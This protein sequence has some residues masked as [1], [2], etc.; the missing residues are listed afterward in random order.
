MLNVN[1]PQLRELYKDLQTEGNI[2]DD[3]DVF[4]QCVTKD[5][6]SG[7][8]IG[9]KKKVAFKDFLKSFWDLCES[10]INITML[11]VTTSD[12]IEIYK[13]R[14]HHPEIM[15][16]GGS[17]HIILNWNK[18]DEVQKEMWLKIAMAQIEANA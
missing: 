16:I 1:W 17:P 5:A 4:F 13:H 10:P 6:R 9:M 7:R 12:G 18:L 3:D 11:V 14:S 15:P 2:K 8:K